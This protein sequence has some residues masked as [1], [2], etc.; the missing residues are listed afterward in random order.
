[1]ANEITTT[2][3]NAV[4]KPEDKLSSAASKIA[5]IYLQDLISLNTAVGVPMT[6]ESKRCATN[7]IVSLVGSLGAEE[8]RKL[9]REQFLQVLQFVTINGLDVF[10]GQV[11]LDKHWNGKEK[12]YDI[13]ATPQGNAYEIMTR[14]FG[15]DVKAVH[16][17]IIVH[18]GEE[19]ILPQ[20]DG[21]NI[22]NMIYKP[23]LD[24]LNNKAV[25]VY[26]IIEKTDGRLEYA[27][28]TRDGV[29]KNLMAQILQNTLREESVNRAELM[30]ELDG[31]TLDELL[32]DPK[33]A[34]YI[35]PTYRSPAS[36]ESMIIAK[37]KKN[38]LLHYTRDLGSA[39]YAKVANVFEED[40]NTDMVVGKNV[41]SEQDGDGAKAEGTKIADF[42]IE[43]PEEPT[44]AP[45]EE[46][47][48]AEVK[49]E[50]PKKAEPKEETPIE[51]KPKGIDVFDLED[52]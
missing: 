12:R 5:N 31:K 30:K 39:A 40:S 8:V 26:Y 28:A 46:P 38:A 22:T 1:M 3:Q 2:K 49:K 47:K 36:K 42:A 27:I 45:A 20:Y 9:P 41:V 32:A 7:A 29:A 13:K 51:E 35:S 25:A 6:E 14:R 44:E 52:L 21:L 18:E 23:K 16:Q 10:S 17:A 24:C 19:L 33:L 11:F 37:M 48:P 15:V 4:E 34:Q 50:E 43:E